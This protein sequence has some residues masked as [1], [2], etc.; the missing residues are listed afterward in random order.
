[1]NR[2][3]NHGWHGVTRSFYMLFLFSSVKLRELRGKFLTSRTTPNSLLPAAFFFLFS[4]FFAY[5]QEVEPSRLATIKFGTET[6][7]AALIQS[8]RTEN[9]DYL[10]DELAALI[11]TTRN[12]KILSGVFGFF[13]DREKT[14][15][16]DRA[17][18]AIE[19]RDDEANETVLSAVE[20]LGKVKAAKASDALMELLDTQ[21]RRF[22]NTAFRALGRT[23]S[24]NKEFADKT[25]EFLIDFYTNRDPGDDNRREVITALGAAGSAK[26]LPLLVELASNADERIPL[27][28]AALD[29]LSKLGDSG[30]LDA[31]LACIG[32]KDPNVRS[33]AVA[34]LGPFSGEQ[35][36]KAILDAFRDSYYRTRIAAAQASRD[37]KLAAAVPYLKFRAERDDVPNVRDEAIRALGAIADDEAMNALDGLFAER[38]NSERVRL[39]SAEMLMKNAAAK[40]LNRLIAELNEAKLKNLTSLYNGF[41]KIIGEAKVAGDTRDM[42]N[43][44]RTFLQSGG[45]MEKLYALDMAANNNLKGL[46]EEIKAMTNEK[47]ESLVRKAKRTAEKLGIEI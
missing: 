46:S 35:V 3:Y 33:A 6:E 4:V 10:D 16:E 27:R 5:A 21:E 38:K 30:G 45:I 44:T 25:A 37:R 43:I 32:T 31:I 41:L 11:E 36:D 14:G 18:R 9:T 39:I 40:N 47:N 23:S 28:I 12:Q 19:E 15:L 22:M 20:Y 7:I 34:A 1:M 8:L 29:A 17:I 26:G 24:V 42:E 2:I 13:G